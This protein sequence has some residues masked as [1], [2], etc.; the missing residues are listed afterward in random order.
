MKNETIIINA[1]VELLTS[2]LEKIVANVKNINQQNMDK[3]I[4]PADQVSN[5]ISKFLMKNDFHIFVS[6]IDNY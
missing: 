4:D 5:L 6:N 3:K 1:N 2:S